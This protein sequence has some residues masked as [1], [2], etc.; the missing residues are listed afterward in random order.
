MRTTITIDE[1]LLDEVRRL[2]AERRQ[3]VSQVIEESVRESL[4]RQ[5]EEPPRARFE[6]LTFDGG[7]YLPGVNLDDNAATLDLMEDR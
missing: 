2:A 1:D 3:T 7:G 5:R 4:L 6:P